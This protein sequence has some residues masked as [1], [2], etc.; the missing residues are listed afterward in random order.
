[1]KGVETIEIYHAESNVEG[2]TRK[3][4]QSSARYQRIREN[5]LKEFMKDCSMVAQKEFSKYKLKG[6]LIGGPG[7]KK[8]DFIKEAHVTIT[9]N[10]ICIKDIG[11]TDMS[12][13]SDLINASE[14]ELADTELMLQKGEISGFLT[15]LAKDDPLVEYGKEIV[16]KAISEARVDTLYV[17]K[18]ITLENTESCSRVIEIDN[19]FTEGKTLESIGGVAAVLRYRA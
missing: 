10:I 14:K 17:T 11:N 9:D 3:G 4:G 1:M 5:Q 12:G 6:I 18:G 16:S 19:T 13:I 2:K 7:P 15:R 8:E